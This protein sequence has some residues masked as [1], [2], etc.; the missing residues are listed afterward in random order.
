M[1]DNTFEIAQAIF[2]KQPGL[3]NSIDLSLEDETS[4]LA[5]KH[6]V[7]E[8]VSNILRIITLHGV[9]IL[10]G[11]IKIKDLTNSQ[12]DLIKEYTRSYGYDLNFTIF[13]NDI[14]INFT[15]VF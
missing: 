13:Q 6:G 3:L 2:S 4:F 10:F 12:I 14:F 5:E 1:D 7:N 15:K 9:K 8:F 11:D